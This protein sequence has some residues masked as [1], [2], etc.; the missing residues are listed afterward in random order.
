MRPDE[1]EDSVPKCRF[2]LDRCEKGHVGRKGR[3]ARLDDKKLRSFPMC[4]DI[5]KSFVLMHRLCG[6]IEEFDVEA[7]FF[8]DS[9]R[10]DE[11][12]R[13][14]E[15][16]AARQRRTSVLT[17]KSSVCRLERRVDKK[18]LHNSFVSSIRLFHRAARKK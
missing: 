15:R 11:P 8:A 3:R 1:E 2:R 12:E 4:P 14:V 17:G 10:V 6:R 18:H 7:V 9:S 13:V 5:G 16:T